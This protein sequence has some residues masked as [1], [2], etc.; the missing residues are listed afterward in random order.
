[1]SAAVML[2]HTILA[3]IM[4]DPTVD[5]LTEAH[6]YPAGAVLVVCPEGCNEKWTHDPVKGFI[7]PP[8]EG[9]TSVSQATKVDF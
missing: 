1:M 6:G 9:A 2:G 3:V 8:S 7:A 5:L 4:A